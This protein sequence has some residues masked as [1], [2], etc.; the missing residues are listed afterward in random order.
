M[1]RNTNKLR[2]FGLA[3]GLAG[4]LGIAGCSESNWQKPT[5]QKIEPFVGEILGKALTSSD[6]IVSFYVQNNGKRQKIFRYPIGSLDG[7]VLHSAFE[8]GDIV[9]IQIYDDGT[10][11]YPVKVKQ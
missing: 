8:K 10:F 3:V 11:D 7:P 2:M 1:E 4:I 6:C 9:E 5:P